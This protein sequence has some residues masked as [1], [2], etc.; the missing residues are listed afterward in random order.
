MP[1]PGHNDLKCVWQELHLSAT[2]ADTKRG[3]M[4][5]PWIWRAIWAAGVALIVATLA[6]A[7]LPY[8]ASTRIVRDRIAWE[9][10][11]WSGFR[12]AI[13]GAPKIE[14]WPQF[15]A[16]LT[17]VTLSKWTDTTNA[18]VVQAERV[19]VE[20][21]AMAA[22]RGDVVFQSALLVR[23]T[24]RLESLA[25]GLFLPPTSTGGR[26]AR[27][28]D[29]ARKVVADNPAAPDQ[30]GLP[31][32][33]FGSVEFH[34]GR[35]IAAVDGKDQEIFTS[36]N[37]RFN[38]AALNAAATLS[39]TGI[40]HGETVALDLS[41]AKPLLL[42][43]GGTA[44]VTVSVK[45]PPA[46]FSFDGTANLS[47][48]AYVEGQA[49][50]AAPSLRRLLEWS[51]TGLT[52]GSA[53]G[54]VAVSSKI[55]GEAKRLKFDSAE[56][57]LNNNPGMGALELSLS[58]ALPAISGTLAFDTLDLRSFLAA[59]TPLASPKGQQD[60]AVDAG[61]A[62]RLNLD[63]RLSAAHASA[64]PIQLANVAATAQV[65]NGLAVFDISDASAFG[66][67]VQ[68]SLRF[69]RK[70]GGTQVEMRLLAS[71]VNGAQF[72][73]AAGMTRL[74]PTGTGTISIILKGPGRAWDSILESANGSI[75]AT[76][77]PGS[78][79]GLNL[80]AFLKRNQQGGFFALDEVS[81][82]TV[83]IDGA[84]LKASISNGVA[85]ID[86][87]E[88]KS[89]KTKIWLSGIVPYAGH[90]LALS[91][92][93]AA[94]DQAQPAQQ[95]AQPAD[96]GTAAA[97]PPAQPAQPAQLSFFV[98]GT[99]NTPFISPIVRAVPGGG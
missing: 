76:F 99:W 24:I 12:V 52:S 69:D 94:T 10:S 36:L 46:T 3:K 13:D 62:D 77:G 88:A 44:P 51:G 85:R 87:A 89:A 49:K 34:D 15:R 16:I 79:T 42:F 65:K 53:I 86:K 1:S 6:F 61:I 81:D 26:I 90:G 32:D 33:A 84:E 43:G 28:I 8:V 54:P 9:M 31:S 82:G 38:W 11:A 18:P 71:D 55:V 91:G 67:N 95:P 64:G 40:W 21:S 56:V 14:I 73:T 7:A 39:A 60:Q 30:N 59:F 23:P 96:G 29:T 27:S 66:G 98:G 70:P 35:M 22:L 48:S 63:L 57:T 25:N 72:G 41:S 50:F 75:S 47:Q 4:P 37:G 74:M 83:P 20:L 5:S 2:A 78:L 68:S 92:S 93:V 80:P 45:T 97:T 58:D 19:E 17:D